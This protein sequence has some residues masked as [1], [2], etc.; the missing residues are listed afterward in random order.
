MEVVEDVAGVQSDQTCTSKINKNKMNTDVASVPD[1]DPF[2]VQDRRL[3][4]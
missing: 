2:A 4:L 3:S 1:S